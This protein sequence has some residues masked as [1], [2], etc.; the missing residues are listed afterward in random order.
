MW[1]K[2]GI[3]TDGNLVEIDDVPRGKT[4]L[5]CPY[6]GGDLIAKKGR[7]KESHFA[8]MGETCRAVGSRTPDDA[9]TLPLYDK[10][11][12]FLTIPE[13]EILKRFWDGEDFSRDDLRPLAKK[14][15][16]YWNP[17]KR[18]LC[19]YDF[20]NQGEIAIG[21]MPLAKF[22]IFQRGSFKFKLM[23]F[24]DAVSDAY[25]SNSGALRERI[26]D[27]QLYRAQIKRLLSQ[28]LY[29]LEV[30]ALGQRLHKIGV[31]ARPINERVEEVL[32][33][34]RGHF[35][36]VS[37][38]VLGTWSHWG[39]VEKYFKYRYQEFNYSIGT[40]TEYFKF[41]HISS[42]MRDLR[43]LKPKVFEQFEIDI[44]DGSL[45]K[46][47]ERIE[48]E[49]RQKAEQERLVVRSQAIKTGM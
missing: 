39:S 18:Q 23:K 36:N 2:Y 24:E 22:T 16:I 5:K 14:D 38:Q 11:G 4:N 12:V 3:D 34:L 25:R 28:T 30:N 29:F 27:L 40:L 44:K 10:F 8:H 49:L 42:V 17:Y 9:P 33:E 13:L 48:E 31:T 45:S 46:I 41:D 37:I 19:K 47:E 21:K 6:C 43:T 15:V 32:R 1:L 26:I 35:Q 20:T 7:I